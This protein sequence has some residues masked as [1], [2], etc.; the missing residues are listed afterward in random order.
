MNKNKP[1]VTIQAPAIL[2]YFELNETGRTILKT[3][4]T[5]GPLTPYAMSK[6]SKISL[7]WIYK[8]LPTLKSLCYVTEAPGPKTRVGLHKKIYSLTFF[9]FC[10]ALQLLQGKDD[11]YMASK[12][13][14]LFDEVFLENF[15]EISQ[16]FGN[17][18]L[19]VLKAATLPFAMHIRVTENNERIGTSNELINN[20]RENF[21]ENLIMAE[22]DLEKLNKICMVPKI[23][24]FLD[25]FLNAEYEE[26]K[27]GLDFLRRLR[28]ELLK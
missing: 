9:G 14:S 7:N 24:A 11:I 8:T 28:S 10:N 4:A 13:W 20:F 17:H 27:K 25:K 12:K 3:L 21:I 6:L 22:E 1:R 26:A 15:D 2:S 5:Q 18:A 16:I 23:R 19:E